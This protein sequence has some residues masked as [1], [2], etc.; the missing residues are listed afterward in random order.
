MGELRWQ[1]SRSAYL[2]L[3]QEELARARG[4]TITASLE[5]VVAIFDGPARAVHCADA[6]VQG[7]RRLGL[8]ARGGLHTGTVEVAG[9]ETGGA[10]VHYA[11]RMLALARPGEVLVSGTVRDLVAGSGISFDVAEGRDAHGLPAEWRLFR[12]GQEPQ[13]PPAAMRVLENG[14]PGAA[15]PILSRREREVAAVLARGLSNREIADEL[16]IATATVERHVANILA[17]LGYRSRTQIAA[18]SAT[19]GLF[20]A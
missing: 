13:S 11:I 19:Q 14:R 20:Q 1:G 3:V 10:T 6:I 17:K 15:L 4:R 18:W 5:N 2:A 8:R 12:V 16:S 7:A 9:A